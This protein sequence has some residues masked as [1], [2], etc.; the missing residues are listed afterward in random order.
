MRTLRDLSNA[1]LQD[2]E[3]TMRP[4]ITG[5]MH[6]AITSAQIG[7][8]RYQLNTLQGGSEVLARLIAAL[9]IEMPDSEAEDAITH[10]LTHAIRHRDYSRK[11]IAWR[12][13]RDE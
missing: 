4:Y 8:E 5:M 11:V 3:H 6:T 2:F 12:Q 10:I 7:Y 13:K 9:T 1:E